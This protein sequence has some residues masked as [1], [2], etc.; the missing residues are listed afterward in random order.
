MIR[1]LNLLSFEEEEVQAVK[2]IPQLDEPTTK[3]KSDEPADS[4]KK[5]KITSEQ[6]ITKVKSQPA[7]VEDEEDDADEEVPAHPKQSEKYIAAQEKLRLL[8]LELKRMDAPEQEIKAKV[9]KRKIS[10]IEELRQTY[11]KSGKAL[12]STHK[13]RDSTKLLKEIDSFSKTLKH[14]RKNDAP[15]AVRVEHQEDWECDLHFIRGCAS[16][17]NTFG[18]DDGDAGDEGWMLNSLKFSKQVGANVYMPKV[19][20]Y[21]VIDPRAAYIIANFRIK[22]ADPFG[23]DITS[24]S[25]V[26]REKSLGKGKSRFD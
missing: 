5:T 24:T 8:K 6:M 1:N 17:R 2:K 10:Q 19:D 14:A 22:K 12:Q 26:W 18:D 4:G 16:C 15:K 21:T 25:D 13:Q 7:P 11:L 9:Q 20:D 3:R 23:R